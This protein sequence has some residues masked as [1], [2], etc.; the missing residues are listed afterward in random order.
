MKFKLIL[1]T[2]LAFG[3]MAQAQGFM[4]NVSV[5]VGVEGIFPG[6]TFQR[7]TAE[8]TFGGTSGTEG[9]SNSVGIVG[10]ARYEFG[11]HSALGFSFT[12]NRSTSVYNAVLSD[13]S[14]VTYVQSN[15]FEM[16]GN[17]I[18]RLPSTERFKP[19]ALI[20]GGIVHF[21]PTNS[22][23]TGGTPQGDSKAAFAYGFGSDFK[24]NDMW[25]I[26]VQYRGLLRTD[27]DFKLSS[28][29][30]GTGLKANVPEPSVMLVYHF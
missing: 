1:V 15:N 26:R 25:A 19:Y 5:G 6:S 17:Y 20:G 30:F 3:A 13:F 18:F 21:S 12:A 10:D 22:F 2:I 23:D 4:S 27:P 7:T 14:S 29:P 11:R 24:M 28:L 8:N 9:T 16:I